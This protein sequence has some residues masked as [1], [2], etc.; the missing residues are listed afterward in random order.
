MAGD[1]VQVVE[2]P[3]ADVPEELLAAVPVFNSQRPIAAWIGNGYAQ[4]DTWDP[5]VSRIYGKS[6]RFS[7]ASG[8]WVLHETIDWVCLVD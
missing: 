1:K 5:E 6:H 2:M 3:L 4:I 7:R 8:S